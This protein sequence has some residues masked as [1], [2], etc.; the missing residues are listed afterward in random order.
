MQ[1]Q[2]TIAGVKQFK[3]QVE[4]T[5]FDHTKLI[6]LMPF[7]RSRAE[8]NIGFDSVEAVFGTSENYKQF[9]GRKFPLQCMADV[10]MSIGSGGRQV[11]DVL[12]VDLPKA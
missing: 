1:T 4:G 2:V 5:D 8:S 3:G 10:E 6:L 12:H 7:S 11:V 9:S